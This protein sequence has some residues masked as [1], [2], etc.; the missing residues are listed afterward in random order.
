[1]KDWKYS[2]SMNPEDIKNALE[3]VGSE[4][5]EVIVIHHALGY[6]KGLE[7]KAKANLKKEKWLEDKW[8][9]T[10]N[11]V[12]KKDLKII[13]LEYN[14]EGWQIYTWVFFVGFIVLLGV[15]FFDVAGK[16]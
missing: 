15:L 3:K 10:H 11:D 16:G 2:E 13:D 4:H 12:H 7:E 8:I 9:K 1:M 5:L 14:K 6:L